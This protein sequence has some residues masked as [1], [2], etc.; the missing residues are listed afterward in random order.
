ML[1][2]SCGS[3]DANNGNAYPQINNRSAADTSTGTDLSGTVRDPNP[4]IVQAD[5]NR[6]PPQ[7][8]DTSGSEPDP[9]SFSSQPIGGVCAADTD[10]STGFCFT[11]PWGGYCT[12][13]CGQGGCPDGSTCMKVPYS[14]FK[15]CYKDC[16]NSEECRSDQYCDKDNLLCMP[17]CESNPCGEGFVCDASSGEC[18]P[19]GSIC[20]EGLDLC[21][22]NDDDC[23]GFT[24]ED[25]TDE[26]CND[27]DDNCDGKIDE[28]CGPG[29]TLPD[30]QGLIDLGKI[31]MGGDA[32]S[33]EI[34]FQL[35][36][37][38][39]SFAIVALNDTNTYLGLWSLTAPDGTV[40][41]NLSDPLN[42]L[43]P[44]LPQIGTFAALISNAPAKY[45]VTP[46]LYRAIFYAEGPETLTH[47]Y[48]ITRADPGNNELVIDLNLYFVGTP[49]LNADNYSTENKFQS[50]LY[51]FWLVMEQVNA[52]A[53]AVNAYDLSSNQAGK[54]TYL[55][56][57]EGPGELEEM[58]ALS[59]M[60]PNSK[61]LNFFFVQDIN[62]YGSASYPLG[63]AGGIPGPPFF[64]GTTASGV[65]VSLASYYGNTGFNSS[66]GVI[67]TAETMA[68]E[69]C[70]Q[71]GLF[72]TSER[73]GE[74][75]DPLTDTPECSNDLNGDGFVSANE[76][77]SAGASN[78]MFWTVTGSAYLSPEQRQVI[79]S[80]PQLRLP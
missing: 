44:S 55:D 38:A 13:L 50:V 65:A 6:V 61:A 25:K 7:N 79:R 24:D 11:D 16:A 51:N 63:V 59:N 42:S 76:C 66:Q 34:K 32:L 39:Y 74:D 27:I 33:P 72:H 71:L 35:P 56:M 19:A 3:G 58:L 47:S 21:N 12:Y 49:G 57:G 1:G 15:I 18:V 40:L 41:T 37:L 46:G 26:V 64:Q 68:H 60:N 67:D 78:L 14:A 28:G 23:D 54:Y 73:D 20:T 5:A 36:N 9:P 8:S 69:G 53:G 77:S 30:G 45:Q 48:V 22:G 10:C 75:H 2:I 43:T 62:N 80:N 70:H 31:P 4:P 29:V 52:V 17:N